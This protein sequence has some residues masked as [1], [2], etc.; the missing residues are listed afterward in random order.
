MRSATTK[1]EERYRAVAL[2]G[3]KIQHDTIAGIRILL[4]LRPSD[5]EITISGVGPH[6]L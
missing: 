4:T 5:A 6:P 1:I 3:N 2:S